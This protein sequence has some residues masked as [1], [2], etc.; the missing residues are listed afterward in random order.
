MLTHHSVIRNKLGLL[1]NP[2]RRLGQ[3]PE[4]QRRAEL[5]PDLGLG[6]Q[7]PGV[8]RRD[9]RR[10]LGASER[11][12]VGCLHHQRDADGEA[13]GCEA[14]ISV[15]PGY[16][17]SFSLSF[18]PAGTCVGRASWLTEDGLL[19]KTCQ[20][21]GC[22]CCCDLRL[23]LRYYYHCVTAV[24]EGKFSLLAVVQ[25][26]CPNR[27]LAVLVLPGT[28]LGLF[29][30]NATSMYYAPGYLFQVMTSGLRAAWKGP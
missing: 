9:A 15:S 7:R 25:C 18:C 29:L 11:R 4:H 12:S 1:Q 13:A 22:H 24:M 20:V 6:G 16:P 23:Y 27:P 21:V 26:P 30:E 19:L 2:R 5:R 14:G 10:G 8:H 17:P 28:M 3:R